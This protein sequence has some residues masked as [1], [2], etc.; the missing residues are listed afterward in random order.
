MIYVTHDQVEAITL[1]DRI[2]VMNT[3]CCSSSAADGDLRAAGQPVRG[4]LHRQPADEPGLAVRRRAD[5]PARSGVT[6]GL[7][8]EALSPAADDAEHVVEIGVDLVEP[9]GNETVVH[10]SLTGG[11]KVIARLGPRVVPSP[12]DR[13]RLAFDRADVHVFDS[14]SGERVS[15]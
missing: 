15:G 8:P 3:A 4:D 10:G 11:G 2:A 12:G 6:V 9:L 13:M 7:R 5:R 1:G 14:A